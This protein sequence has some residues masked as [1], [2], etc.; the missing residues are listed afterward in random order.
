M[1]QRDYYDVLG[2]GKSAT[3]AE[4]KKAHRKLARKYHPD[5][6][7][8]DPKAAEKFQ[9]VQEAYE[10]LSDPKKR[11]RYDEFGHAAVS[12]SSA[13]QDA[14]EA[15]RRSQ[16]RGRG[17]SGGGGGYGGGGSGG[18]RQDFDPSEFGNGQFGTMFD[19]LFGAR[20]PFG[21]GGGRQRPAQGPPPSGGGDVEYPVTLD[22]YQAAR[23]TTMPLQIRRGGAGETIDVK[24]PGG[25]KQGS[26]VR[27][28]GKGEAGGDL[29]IVVNLRPHPYL[30]RDG[31]NVVM[32]LP[33]SWSE[34][35][36]GGRVT[37]PTLDEDVTLTVPPG[38]GSGTKLRIKGRGARRGEEVGDQHCV[39]KIVVPKVLTPEARE[40][41]ERLA[42]AAPI[43][44]RRDAGW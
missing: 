34:A 8:D 4:V 42:A 18:V 6:A 32:D 28:R 16:T 38:T 30:R 22:F 21:R 5:I 25:V 31:L 14:Y 19:E 3:A 13:Q 41:A 37:V 7:K 29:F 11:Q 10:I 23:G 2:V 15:F 1:P 12:G 17:G 39:V 43:E 36:L 35:L 20:G 27:V 33:V 26:R 40:L 9:E 24:I 44:P